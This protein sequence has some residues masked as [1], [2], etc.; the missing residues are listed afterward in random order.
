MLLLWQGERLL[1]L[2][3]Q[4]PDVS[5]RAGAFMLMLVPALPLAAVAGIARLTAAAL[6]RPG[7][8]FVV[9]GLALGLDLLGNWALI[10]GH[11][12]A[13]ALGLVG[14]AL[15]NLLSFAGMVLAYG[16]IFAA[17][18]HL[19]R[20]HLFGYWYRFDGSRAWQILRLGAPIMATWVLE[21]G[22]F[23]GAAVLMGLIGVTE[24]AAHAIALNVAAYAFQIPFGIAQAATV[25]VGLAYGARDKNWIA[26]AGSMALVAGIGVMAITAVAMWT[27]PRLLV[28]LYIDVNDPANRA[29][30]DL[31]VRF[32]AIAAIFQ[33]ADGAQAVAAGILRGLQD[34]RIPMLIALFGYWGIGFCCS[35]ALGFASPLGGVGIWWGLAA[36]LMT[37]AML[38]GTR[39]YRRESLKLTPPALAS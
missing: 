2:L 18:R 32:L 38:L 27:V 16:L 3:G 17:D 24:V 13:P 10:F 9:T 30:A 31:A 36:G 7:W 19:K 15:A 1:V 28:A 37:V 35:V 39:W 14:S 26:I 29:V 5:R 33:L 22:L 21:G 8:T 20:Y 6:G 4:Q 12:G 25:R 23:G 11:L 34:T